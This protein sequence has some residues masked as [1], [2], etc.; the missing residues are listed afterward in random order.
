VTSGTDNHA[1][2][3]GSNLIWNSCGSLMEQYG[4]KANAPRI[5][6]SAK[7]SFMKVDANT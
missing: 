6:F 5:Q 3:P 1:T 2:Y 7:S 4:L